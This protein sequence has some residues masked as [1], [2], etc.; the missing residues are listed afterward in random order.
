[1]IDLF[2]P[3]V[4]RHSG[5]VVV[6]E[7]TRKERKR[8]QQRE[9]CARWRAKNPGYASAAAKKRRQRVNAYEE[10]KAWR[11]KNPDMFRGQWMRRLARLKQRAA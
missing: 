5:R 1:M 9:A 11:E 3:P 2:F 4:I 7:E 8:R 6:A 10:T